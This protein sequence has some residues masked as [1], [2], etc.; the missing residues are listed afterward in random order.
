MQQCIQRD[1]DDGQGIPIFQL[2]CDQPSQRLAGAGRQNDEQVFPEIAGR[3]LRLQQ[4]GRRC[5]CLLHRT[6]GGAVVLENS[7]QSSQCRQR[8]FQLLR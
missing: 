7:T 6:E 2:S 3:M 8:D 5:L 1:D 4:H